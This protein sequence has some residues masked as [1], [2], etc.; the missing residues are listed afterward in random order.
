MTKELEQFKCLIEKL[1]LEAL[2]I[3][4]FELGKQSHSHRMIQS[5]G[6]GAFGS[7]ALEDAI[8]LNEQ[9]KDILINKILTNDK[10]N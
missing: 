1:P 9:K 4:L 7:K 2:L 3:F 8:E 10:N 6:G 5:E